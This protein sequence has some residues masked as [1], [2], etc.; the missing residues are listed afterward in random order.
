MLTVRKARNNSLMLFIFLEDFYFHSRDIIQMGIYYIVIRW[1]RQEQLW[2][3]RKISTEGF[4]TYAEYIW[5][6]NNYLETGVLTNRQGLRCRGRWIDGSSRCSRSW[7]CWSELTRGTVLVWTRSPSATHLIGFLILILL[8]FW[9]HGIR[10]PGKSCQC[11]YEMCHGAYVSKFTIYQS[12]Q[13]Y[14]FGTYDMTGQTVH[15]TAMSSEHKNIFWF[16]LFYKK[17]INR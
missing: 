3:L 15:M 7:C 1:R 13:S 2:L 5:S 6:T 16:F 11:S 10:F 14:S 4:T 9:G 12:R 8:S 17:K